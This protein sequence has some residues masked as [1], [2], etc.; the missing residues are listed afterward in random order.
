MSRRVREVWPSAALQPTL[1]GMQP[2]A[3][4]AV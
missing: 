3:A 2:L 4:E 1:Y